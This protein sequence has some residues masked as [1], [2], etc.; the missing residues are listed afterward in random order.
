MVK[1]EKVWAETV[2]CDIRRQARRKYS[3][4]EKIRLA[5]EGLRNEDNIAELCRREGINPNMYYKWSKGFLE[6]GKSTPDC[7]Y[8]TSSHQR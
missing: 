4:E 1:D 8:Q 3:A 6:A 7:E 5:L 2:V